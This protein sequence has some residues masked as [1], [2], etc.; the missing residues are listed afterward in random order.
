MIGQLEVIVP[1]IIL[2][3]IALAWIWMYA[4]T[5]VEQRKWE[6]R[7]AELEAKLRAR[8]LDAERDAAHC[9]TRR[10]L[11]EARLVGASR[12]DLINRL[13]VMLA[14]ARKQ[15]GPSAGGAG[16]RKRRQRGKNHAD[17]G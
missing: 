17:R 10:E 4:S 16:G 6:K 3:I 2:A 15:D 7:D 8:E 11:D 1:Y 9:R 13:Q 14:E 5:I 12:L